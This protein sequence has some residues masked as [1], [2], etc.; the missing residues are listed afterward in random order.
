MPLP[1][2]PSDAW[3][4]GERQTERQRDREAKRQ[5]GRDGEMERGERGGE[6]GYNKCVKKNQEEK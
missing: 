2:P 1:P 3:E 6:S 5:R 4:R